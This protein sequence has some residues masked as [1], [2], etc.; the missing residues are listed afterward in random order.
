MSEQDH[1]QSAPSSVFTPG[2]AAMRNEDDGLGGVAKSKGIAA[3]RH[4]IVAGVLVLGAGLLYFMRQAGTGPRAANAEVAIDYEFTDA[5]AK[6]RVDHQEEVID[7]LRRAG[8]P[9]QL[10]PAG[11]GKNPFQLTDSREAAQESQAS[12]DQL[13]DTRMSVALQGLRLQAVI[14]G[15]VP[16]ARISGQTYRVGDRVGDFFTIT[17]IGGR[18]VTLNGPEGDHR[19]EM[20]KDG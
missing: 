5:E 6:R 19:L 13:K 2:L 1:D 11:L 10:P 7:D 15:R 12:E 20:N 3:N 4:A 18:G 9:S 8:P 17:E 16:I 14:N